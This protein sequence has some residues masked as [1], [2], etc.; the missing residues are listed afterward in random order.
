MWSSSDAW[1]TPWLAWGVLP[2][3]SANFG[4]WLPML[5]LEAV[6]RTTWAAARFVQHTS[7]PRRE[8]IDADQKSVA[9]LG[10]QIR[11]SAWALL[12][13]NALVNGL[14]SAALLP[15][16][17]GTVHTVLPSVMQAL[18]HLVLMELIGDFGLYWG[19]RI[20]HE[21]EWLWRNFHHKHHSIRTPT[22]ATTI[23]IDPVDATLQ[24]GLP[25]ILSAA[26]VRPHPLV[27]NIYIALRIGE[28]VLNHS[29]LDA[30]VIDALSLKFLPG[31][32]RIAHHDYHH[33][34][35][36][37]SKNAKNLGE[38][39]WFWDWAFGTLSSHHEKRAR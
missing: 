20:Q 29:G 38:N 37:Y 11:T 14:I 17:A 22:A 8:K 2:L 33:C 21:S 15:A 3:V 30:G 24:A 10:E 31:R 27:F 4:Y 19:H 34:F 9:S 12:G 6:L 35:S 28:N 5:V 25:V 36:N 39:F 23:Y 26:I 7:T 32:A 13:P 16:V 18:K 1:S